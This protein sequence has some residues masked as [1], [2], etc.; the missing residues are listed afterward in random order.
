MTRL[1]AKDFII[2]ANAENI[3]KI[4]ERARRTLEMISPAS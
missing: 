1:Y 4:E 2:S 3:G